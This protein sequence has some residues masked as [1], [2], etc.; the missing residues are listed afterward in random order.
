MLSFLSTRTL[1]LGIQSRLLLV[2]FAIGSL[3]VLYIAFN[4]ARQ[5]G[6]ERE[7]VR[8]QMRLVAELVGARL[9][10]HIGDVTQL[11]NAI[12][13]TL[14]I[15]RNDTAR[16]DATLRGLAAELPR[17]TTVSLWAADGSNIGSSEAPGTG[18]RPSAADRAFFVAARRGPGLATEAPVRLRKGG[19]WTAV[20]A[21]PLVRDDRT[22]AVVSVSMRLETLPGLLDPDRRLPAGAVI[23]LSSLDGRILARSLDATQWIGQPV[24]LDR[25]ARLRPLA[26]GRGDGEAIGLDGVPRI[27]GFARARGA[28]WLV[29]VGVPVETALAQ[30]RATS[31]ETLAIGLGMLAAGL[32]ISAWVARRI[33]R[34]LHQLSEDARRLGEGDLEHRSDVARNDEV[35][36]LAQTLN[37]MADAL[38]ERIAAARRSAER[39]GLALE[40]SELALFDWDLVNNRIHYSARAS[41][42]RGGPDEETELTPLARGDLVH[43]DDLGEVSERL[44]AAVRGEA[45]LFEAE[46]RIRRLD[47]TWLWVRSRGRVVEHDAKGRALRLV[48]TEADISRRKAAEEEL[49][50]RAEFDALTGLPNRALFNDRIAGAMA[51]ATRSGQTLALLYLDLDHFKQVNDTHGHEAGDA[52]LRVTAGRLKACVRAIDTV[53]R[54]GG[55]EFTVILE[56]LTGRGDAE[57]IAAKLVES[58]RAPVTIGGVVVIGST[59]VGVALMR[60]GENDA[61]AFLRRADEALYEAKRRGR[62]RFAVR[63]ADEG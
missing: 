52:L 19:E 26:D 2:T 20:F 23:S 9:D 43:P 37:R 45:P 48:G 8:E 54:L 18:P 53:A 12:A 14:P 41:L 57:A 42:L 4:T 32:L 60:R 5:A 10:D 21:L 50:Q 25:V 61:A 44:N 3:F 11:L 56:G 33:A 46:F 30:A 16:N 59:S 27:F 1:R 47:G 22:I 13:G 24:P 34:P 58:M 39:L 51:R 49:R 63:Q 28:P 6:R 17:N 29:F 31:R 7:H 36:V 38:Q 55:D 15:E 35:G 62:D 40:G